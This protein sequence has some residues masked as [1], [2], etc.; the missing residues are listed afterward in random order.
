MPGKVRI[1]AWRVA[2]NTLATIENKHKRTLELDA[3]CRICGNGRENEFHAVVMCTKSR[4][5]RSAMRK[6]WN[7]PEERSFWYTGNNW[8]QVLLDSVNEETRAKI[9]LLF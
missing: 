1:F 3:I 2:T 4:G 9:L 6:V 5:L 8:L 7:L